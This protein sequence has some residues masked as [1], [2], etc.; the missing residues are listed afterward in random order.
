MN[1]Q[2]PP[3]MTKLHTFAANGQT[4]PYVID[5]A[6]ETVMAEWDRLG[7]PETHGLMVLPDRRDPDHHKWTIFSSSLSGW[8]ATD[9][10]EPIPLL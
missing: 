10:E 5:V 4:R 7:V 1:F 2:P 3:V 6:P 8:D 9:S